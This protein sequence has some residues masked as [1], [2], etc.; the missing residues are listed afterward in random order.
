MTMERSWAFKL[1]GAD[2]RKQSS[3]ASPQIRLTRSKQTPKKFAGFAGYFA[4]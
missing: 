2:P 3:P 1:P 4:L